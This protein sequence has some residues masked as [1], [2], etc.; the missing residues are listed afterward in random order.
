M[1]MD[2][3]LLTD[4]EWKEFFR[5][6]DKIVCADGSAAEKAEEIKFESREYGS[7]VELEE[8]VNWFDE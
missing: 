6:L 5:L 4:V 7:E 3:P 1:D 2:E 8:F